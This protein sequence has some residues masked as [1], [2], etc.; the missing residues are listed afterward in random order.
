M[1]KLEGNLNLGQDD[2][3]RPAAV[4]VPSEDEIALLMSLE[5]NPAWQIYKKILTQAQK[6]FFHM[7]MAMEETNKVMK[8]IGMVV[9]IN[10]SINQLDAMILM[11]KAAQQ[12]AKEA[13]P[14]E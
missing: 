8:T 7:T 1:T 9:G 5:K 13:K 2:Q 14:K 4:Y 3:G 10:Y 11:G 6:G 12:K